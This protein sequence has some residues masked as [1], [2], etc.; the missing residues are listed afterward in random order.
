[1]IVRKNIEDSIKG[2]VIIYGHS[3]RKVASKA[4]NVKRPEPFLDA[5][6]FVKLYGGICGG[7]LGKDDAVY[8]K[9]TNESYNKL[10]MA[11]NGYK[12]IFQ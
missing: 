4:A 5:I 10:F 3:T 6:N 11:T 8:K 2:A 7:T 12:M 9:W 1:M